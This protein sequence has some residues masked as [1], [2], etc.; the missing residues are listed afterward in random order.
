MEFRSCI[1]C[2]Q[3]DVMPRLRVGISR[4][5]GKTSVERTRTR[6]IL[7][8]GAESSGLCSS[9]KCGP[10]H[11]PALPARLQTGPPVLLLLTSRG[12]TCSTE[13][14][15]EG[16]LSLLQLRTLLLLL[17]AEAQSF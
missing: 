7:P 17:R 4:P 12:Q 14:E 3:A 15:Q 5:T 1:D 11:L 2:L 16:A 9:P 6:K 10:S 13:D 8:R